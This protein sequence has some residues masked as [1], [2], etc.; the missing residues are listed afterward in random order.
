MHAQAVLADW[1]TIYA[2]GIVDNSTQM[3]RFSDA[4]ST[5]SNFA[6]EFSDAIPAKDWGVNGMIGSLSSFLLGKTVNREKMYMG[7]GADINTL[8]E[9]V[10]K[11]SQ[12]DQIILYGCSR[13]AATIINYMA[14]NNSANVQAL[15]LDACPTDMP[16][17]LALILAKLGINPDHALTIF[18]KIFPAYPKNSIPPIQAIKQIKNK[19]L[20]I[21]LLHAQTDSRVSYQNSFMLYQ[22]FKCQGFNQ[23]HLIVLPEGKHSFLL[24]D[25]TIKP[26]YLKAVHSFYKTYGLPYDAQWIKE[27]LDLNSLTPNNDVM[28][29]AITEYQ[30]KINDTYQNALKRNALTAATI[31]TL[32]IA[33]LILKYN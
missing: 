13:G 17:T 19:N 33:Y 26:T 9:Q 22:E 2:H 4:I 16:A 25:E 27:E 23:V 29:R 6:L 20:P 7:Q 8:H 18:T 31:S 12:N 11:L 5:S 1:H 14:E 21:L 3:N 24:Q 10:S 30:T 32:I 15:V 28:A